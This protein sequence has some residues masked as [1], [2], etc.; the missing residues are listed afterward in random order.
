MTAIDSLDDRWGVA[1]WSVEPNG[2]VVVFMDDGGIALCDR[3][4]TI[5]APFEND[6]DEP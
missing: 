2:S 3:D 1:H 5:D 4:A 6:E